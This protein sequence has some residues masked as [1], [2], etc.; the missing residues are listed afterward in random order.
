MK[1]AERIIA[2][3]SGEPLRKLIAELEEE[4]SWL[5]LLP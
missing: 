5:K 2:E 1:V 3:E 4:N